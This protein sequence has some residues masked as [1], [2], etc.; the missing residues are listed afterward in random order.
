MIPGIAAVLAGRGLQCKLEKQDFRPTIMTMAIVAAGFGS[1]YLAFLTANYRAYGSFV[2][3][4]FKEGNFTAVIGSLQSIETGTRIFRVPVSNKA[5]QMAADVSPAFQPLAEVLRKGGPLD[6]WRE[7]G[8]AVNDQACDEIGG[9]WFVWALRDAG[10][11][12]G[13]YASPAVASREFG[14]IA[15]QIRRACDSGKLNCRSSVV[16]LIPP[17][18][19]EQWRMLPNAVLRAIRL[20]SLM[21]VPRVEDA[22]PIDMSDMATFNMYWRFLNYPKVIAPASELA[23]AS[24]WFHDKASNE[25]PTLRVYRANNSDAGSVAKRLP[26]PDIAR[27]FS[28]PD[29][30]LNRFQIIHGC[31]ADCT[32]AATFRD[33]TEIRTPLPVGTSN[34]ASEGLRTLYIDSN[35]P[36]I[37]PS[38][39]RDA[40]VTLARH[41]SN[42]AFRVYHVVFPTLLAAGLLGYLAAIVRTAW[43]RRV[44]P[45]IVV[46]TAAWSLVLA[47]EILIALVDVTSFP[48]VNVPYM[49]PAAYLAGI[50]AVLSLCAILTK[51]E[52]RKI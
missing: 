10:A 43:N 50:A 46:A 49:A 38:A 36:H 19:G 9:G 25:W 51:T 45:V 34:G 26:S 24:G 35:I 48:A 29:A 39:G 44:D 21:V 7:P 16:D 1:I 14:K 47:R 13:F 22:S 2:G 28:D 3:V 18:S 23:T 31:R 32:I 30:N 41:F 17:I 6:G 15:E 40:G 8:C 37:H 33:G 5:M 11:L 20:I 42:A 27:V 4:D 52:A 12:K